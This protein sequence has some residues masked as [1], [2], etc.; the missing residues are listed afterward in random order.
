[1]LE[2]ALEE[3][4]SKR[5]EPSEIYQEIANYYFILFDQLGI[6]AFDSFQFSHYEDPRL[7]VVDGKEYDF[8][9]VF[10]HQDVDATEALCA[11]DGLIADLEEHQTHKIL[12]KIEK[13]IL[14]RM[15]R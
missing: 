6:S 15:Q 13:C 3:E 14:N 12:K 10:C 11:I 7:V 8:D 9:Q 4:L 1:M 2:K 5:K